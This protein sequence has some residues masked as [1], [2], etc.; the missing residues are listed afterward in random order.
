M[1]D[2]SWRSKQEKMVTEALERGLRTALLID[3]ETTGLDPKEGA[4]CIEVAA[5]RFDLH[6]AQAVDIYSSLIRHDGGND[7]EEINNI[8][9]AMVRAAPRPE[10]V[11]KRIG[12]MIDA[13]DLIVSHRVE[14]DYQFL[15]G[16]LRDQRPWC[17]SKF[18]IEWP[19]G[20]N[21][22]DLLHLALANGCGVVHAHRALSDTEVLARIFARTMERH[23]IHEILKQALRTKVLVI[24]LAPFMQKDTVKEYGF[25]WN[26]ED[27]IWYKWMPRED[28]GKLPF[29]TKISPS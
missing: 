5:I 15:P 1:G 23:D 25:A 17:C 14:F 7:A 2:N 24:S 29:K 19:F 18:D 20:K 12:R 16:D 4:V 26:A 3:T 9:V 28:V 13:S 6:H 21:G 27:K 8:P 10:I 22:S 11:W